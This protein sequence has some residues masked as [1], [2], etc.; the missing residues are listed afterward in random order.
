MHLADF[1]TSALIQEPC[2]QIKAHPNPNNI[3]EWHYVI[4]GHKGSDFEGGVYHGDS[5]FPK[6]CSL[7]ASLLDHVI[8]SSNPLSLV[9]KS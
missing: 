6:D 2:P 3:L 1:I 7:E 8:G 9:R 4:E 5:S